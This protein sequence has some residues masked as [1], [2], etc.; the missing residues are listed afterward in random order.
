MSQSLYFDHNAST[1]ILS[2]VQEAMQPF[3]EEAYGNPSSGHW[4]GQPARQAVEKARAQVAV[5][6]GAEPEEI[7]FTSGGSEANNA[8]IKGVWFSPGRS[9]NRV[10][11][12]PMEH[13]ATLEPCQFLARQGADV[14]MLP[15]DK[16]GRLDPISLERVLGQDLL[17][18][19]VM[20]ANNEVGTVQPIPELAELAHRVGA[21]I[22][23]DAAQSA[24]KTPVKVD[25]MKV[26]LLSVAGHKLYAPKGVGALYVRRGTELEP[27]IHGAG[28]EGGRRSGTE[29]ALLAVGLGAACAAAGRDLASYRSVN[30]LRDRLW[31]KLRGGLGDSVLM[32]GHPSFRLPNTL[33]VAFVGCLGQEILSACPDLAASTGAACHGGGTHLSDT[34]R[35]MGVAPEVGAGTVRLSLG[36]HTTAAEVDRAAEMLIAAFGQNRPE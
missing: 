5:F 6:L 31:E 3:L 16:Y 9:R 4:A 19:T 13:P 17:L 23:T 32:Q 29:S 24:G 8:A 25:E 10:V 26:D 27:L 18:V 1:P 36:K 14:E 30:I 35:A 33:S 7:V 20:H 22:H 11:T 28:H 2:E 34:L 15:V 12:T 21:I